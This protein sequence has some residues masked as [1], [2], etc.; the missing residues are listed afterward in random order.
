[1]VAEC[2]PSH[3][4][5]QARHLSGQQASGAAEARAT[6]HLAALGPE[7]GALDWNGIALALLAAVGMALTIRFAGKAIRDLFAGISRSLL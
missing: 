1:M 4:P 5:E 2:S 7:F 3:A 6:S